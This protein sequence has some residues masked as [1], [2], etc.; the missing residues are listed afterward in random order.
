[1]LMNTRGLAELIVLN[2]G[3]QLRVINPRM[4]AIL[5][6]MSLVTT[7]A[8]SPILQLI[9]RDEIATAKSEGDVSQLG[10]HKHVEL[11]RR[12]LND[13]DELAGRS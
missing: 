6:I 11:R 10:L 2:I 1:V 13:P 3:L 7:L 8:T 9:R 5:V 12:S 4:F